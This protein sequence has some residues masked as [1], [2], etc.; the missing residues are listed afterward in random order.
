VP[1][2]TQKRVG[3]ELIHTGVGY[4]YRKRLMVSVIRV[5]PGK[6]SSALVDTGLED[7]TVTRAPNDHCVVSFSNSIAA[8]AVAR[9]VSIS[10]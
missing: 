7:I 10:S 9:A 8:A 3:R 4:G 2:C 1:N 5:L 6:H